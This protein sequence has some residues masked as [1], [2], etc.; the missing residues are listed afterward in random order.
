[1]TLTNNM[2]VAMKGCRRTSSS[3]TQT[4]RR[5]SRYTVESMETWG[6]V[7]TSTSRNAITESNCTRKT[8]KVSERLEQELQRVTLVFRFPAL[9]FGRVRLEP[10]LKYQQVLKCRNVIRGR[11]KR[12]L[13]RHAVLVVQT[14]PCTNIIIT[15][16][17]PK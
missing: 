14:K 6:G 17:V 7:R 8:R 5:I 10:L 12:E 1:M 13:G 4:Q 3:T 15:N 16:I 11:A 9:E 2:L